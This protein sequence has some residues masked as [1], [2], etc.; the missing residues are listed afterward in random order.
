M[1]V[2]TQLPEG[3]NTEDRS[4]KTDYSDKLYAIRNWYFDWMPKLPGQLRGYSVA[5]LKKNPFKCEASLD[6]CWLSYALENISGSD[7]FWFCRDNPNII[8]ENILYGAAGRTGC[9]YY[10]RRRNGYLTVRIG[11][12]DIPDDPNQCPRLPHTYLLEAFDKSGIEVISSHT[13]TD[14]AFWAMVD[15]ILAEHVIPEEHIIPVSEQA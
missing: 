10:V 4:Y 13:D 15:I 8:I 1:P 14:E 2:I 9:D 12:G 7:R 11:N 3:V 5:L 6:I